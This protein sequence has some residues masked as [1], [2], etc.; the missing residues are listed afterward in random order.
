MAIRTIPLLLLTLTISYLSPKSS[1]LKP[2]EDKQT[3][4]Q[5]KNFSWGNPPSLQSWQ[6]DNHNNNKSSTTTHYKWTGI[7]CSSDG[8]ITNISLPNQNIYGPFRDSL[9]NLTNLIHIDLYNNSISGQFPVSLY[10]C[11]KLQYLEL[12]HNLLVGVIPSDIN[13]M[14][15]SLTY[16]SLSAN[17]FTGEIHGTIGALNLANIDIAINLLLGPIP[18]GFGKL[19]N[20]NGLA[21]F[22][23]NF[24]SEIPASIGLL[25]LL[26]N[27]R[28]F[29]NASPGVAARVGKALKAW[30]FEVGENRIS[31][32]YR[33]SLRRGG[34]DIGCSCL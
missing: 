3:L 2:E 18:Q 26:T 24:S 22:Y 29:R 30:N 19:K 12:A 31:T 13:R 23:N 8:F 14:S 5:I 25:P 11:S 1:S 28:L 17:N 21:M 20:L 16:L 15:T 7:H 10:K 34:F 32:R 6:D 4:L 27:I 9:C 33:W